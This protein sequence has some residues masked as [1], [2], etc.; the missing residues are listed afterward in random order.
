MNDAHLK[1]CLD[2]LDHI[3]R[4]CAGESRPSNRSNWIIA[5]AKAAIENREFDFTLRRHPQHRPGFHVDRRSLREMIAAAAPDLPQEQA[6]AII[7]Q[8]L[9]INEPEEA[10]PKGF[11][12]G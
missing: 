5:R 10:D 8:V 1:R 9:R 12:G 4:V 2:A 7:N 11:R 6:D 3:S